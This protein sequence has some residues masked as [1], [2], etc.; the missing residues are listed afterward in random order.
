[1]VDD[2]WDFSKL[3]HEER[4]DPADLKLEVSKLINNVSMTAPDFRFEIK[5]PNTFAEVQQITLEATRNL[6]THIMKTLFINKLVPAYK[7]YVLSQEP[8]LLNTA[9]NTAR[10]MWKRKNPNGAEMPKVQKLTMSPITSEIENTLKNFPEDIRDD[11][12]VAIKNKKTT[13]TPTTIKAITRDKAT[14]IPVTTTK[15]RAVPGKQKNKSITGYN[16]ITCWFCNKKG[17]TQIDC[18]TRLKQ[19]KPL[20]WRNKEV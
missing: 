10:A 7:D 2:I 3:K 4:D 19:N 12:I 18:R 8:D 14:N 13:N 1:M 11:C 6:K 5:E 20:T 9:T 16:T 15:I 17:H